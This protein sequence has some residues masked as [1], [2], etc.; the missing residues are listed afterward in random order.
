MSNGIPLPPEC[1]VQCGEIA[2]GFE[3]IG[4]VLERLLVRGDGGAFLLLIFE[5]YRQIEVRQG[6]LWLR[7]ERVPVTGFRFR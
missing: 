3:K 4:R 2:V 6:Q 7:P 5:H 1:F